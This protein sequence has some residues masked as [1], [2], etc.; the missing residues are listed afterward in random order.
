MVKGGVLRAK[1]KGLY[2]SRAK[3]YCVV[4]I[5]TELRDINVMAQS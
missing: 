5:A 2:C 3:V 4:S 1:G